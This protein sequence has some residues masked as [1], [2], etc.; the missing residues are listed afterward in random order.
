GHTPNHLSY[1]VL[2][3]GEPR[4]VL[5]GGSL[6]YGTVG[7]TDLISAELTDTLTR[8]QFH[9]ARRLMADLPDPTRVLPTH[10]FGSFCASSAPSAAGDGAMASEKRQ[11]LAATCAGEDEFVATVVAGLGPYPSYYRFMAPLNRR[12]PTAAAEEPVVGIGVDE[13]HRRIEDGGWVIDTRPRRAFAQ[14]H[15]AGSV[16]MEF[17]PNY[18]STYVGWLAPFEE[19]I[20]L[21]ADDQDQ[22][23]AARRDLMRIGL[24][25]V[26]GSAV[27]L[28]GD[29]SRLP[30]RSYP[31]VDFRGLAGSGAPGASVLDVRQRDEWRAGHIGGSQNIP[32]QDLPHR[33][34]ELPDGELWVHCQSGYRASVA[35]SLLDRAGRTVVLVDDDFD[36][37]PMAGL[38]IER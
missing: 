15:L 3:H 29:P 2:E 9:S 36:R 26:E 25:R 19:P 1:L 34:S 24:D 38:S 7:R 5:T 14:K 17:S 20:T 28:G 10:G 31:V 18:F 32:I 4:A 11:N 21:I 6:L 35:A 37:A 16:G 13:V 27:G 12:G 23:Q 22:L 33:L 8:Q 30:T